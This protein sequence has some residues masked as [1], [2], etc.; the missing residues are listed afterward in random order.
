MRTGNLLT[1]M[2]EMGLGELGREMQITKS[3]TVCYQ[4]PLVSRISTWFTICVMVAI[5]PQTQGITP[6]KAPDRRHILDNKYYQT[7]QEFDDGDRGSPPDVHRKYIN[8]EEEKELEPPTSRLQEDEPFH[9]ANTYEYWTKWLRNGI[10]MTAEGLAVLIAVCLSIPVFITWILPKL[11]SCLR[12]SCDYIMLL[13]FGIAWFTVCLIYATEPLKKL[14]SKKV[15][16]ALEYYAE[17]TASFIALPVFCTA[18]VLLLTICVEC[19][20]HRVYVMQ[21]LTKLIKGVYHGGQTLYRRLL[22]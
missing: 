12:K 2:G 16:S 9:S 21:Q 1:G 20:W 5:T 14:I 19:F 4:F 10:R 6:Y 22:T 8:E 11:S 13:A 7:L 18:A 15:P 17:S 3:H